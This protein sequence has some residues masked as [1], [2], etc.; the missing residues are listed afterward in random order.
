VARSR[1]GAVAWT[2]RWVWPWRDA[3]NCRILRC[4]SCLRDGAR[5][6]RRGALR[7]IRCALCRT[8]LCFRSF[9]GFTPLSRRSA[10]RRLQWPGGLRGLPSAGGPARPAAAARCEPSWPGAHVTAR[11]GGVLP[12]RRRV[13]RCGELLHVG[14]Y[15]R[16]FP[17]R[18]HASTYRHGQQQIPERRGSG[19]G[20]A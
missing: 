15:V 19:K 7:Q 20:F 10:A 5:R 2:L 11:S 12:P 4:W 13:P 1:H 18:P 16:L 14:G 9:L 8:W 3:S 17:L 6:K